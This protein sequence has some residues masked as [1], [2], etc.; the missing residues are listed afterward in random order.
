MKRRGNLFNIGDKIVYPMHGAGVIEDVETKQLAGKDVDYYKVK[1]NCGNIM[2]MV[3]VENISGV[4]L[5]AVISESEAK[6]V[7]D[8]FADNRLEC[9]LPWNKRYKFNVDMLKTGDIKKV[10]AVRCELINRE[11]E[12]GLSTSDRKM[13]ILTKNIFCSEIATALKTTPADI[14]EQILLKI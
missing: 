3:P 13:F 6:A 11:K 5:R 10:A 9:D 2:L 12:H 7:L 14:F 8:S 4:Q 1:I